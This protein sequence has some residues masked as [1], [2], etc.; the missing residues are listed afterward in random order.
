MSELSW[1]PEV[2]PPSIPYDLTPYTATMIKEAL[3]KKN[4]NS[5]PGDDCIL[6][7]YL[8]KMPG[9]HALLAELFTNIRDLSE[10]P[11]SW[12][13]S[14]VTLMPKDNEDTGDPTHFRMIALTSNV[15]KLYHTLESS[16][17]MS[18]MISNKY[19]DP[20]AQKA[21]VEGVNGCVE[22]VQVVQEVI[23]NAK[24]NH[25]TAYI[26]WIDLIDA[27]GSIIHML[28]YIVLKHYHLPDQIIIYIK[29]IYSKL[30]GRVKTKDWE[31]NTFEF[32]KGVFQGDPYSGT[33]FLI[34][35][36]PLIEYIKKHKE[37]QGYMI[38]D[39][40]QNTEDEDHQKTSIITTPFA[41]DFNLIS[42]N[43]KQHQNLL[44]DVEQ[45]AQSMGLMFK[46]QKCRSLSIS[47]G[48]VV[49]VKFVLT[50][51]SDINS[52][53]HIETV[54]ERPHKFLGSTITKMNSANDFFKYFKE[55]LEEK[56]KNIDNSKIRGEHKLSI[57]E[58][59]TLPSMRF[60][61]SIHDIHNTHLDQLDN[62]VKKYIK[63]WLKYPTRG[64]T[65]IG[66][67][68]PYMLKVKQPSQLYL[69]GH[70]GNIAMMR[71]KGDIIVNKC[72][73]SKINR[74]TKWKKKS[75][76]VVKC[77]N[78]VAELVK[79]N[80]LSIPRSTSISKKHINQAKKEVKIS[81][82]A[83]I[84]EKWD[85]K[86]KKLVMQGNFAKLLLE[87]KENATW[88][89]IA[90]KMPRNVLA[91][92]TRIST[93][94]LPSPDNLKRWGKRKISTCP[95]CRNP[96]GTLAHLVN[97]CPVA[98]KQKR[99]TWRHDSV[100]QHLTKEVKKLATEDTQVYSD[101][102]GHMIN[103]TTIPADILVTSGEGS[104]PDLVLINRRER[105][106]ALL[107]LTCPLEN[108]NRKAHD[109]KELKYTQLQIDLEEK[110]FQVQLVP[111]E[112]GSSGHIT[113]H[114][115]KSLE[116]VL[117]KYS[118]RMKPQVVQNLAKISLL[119]TMSIFHAYQTI[120]WV[121]PPL[122]EP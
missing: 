104:K 3:N 71:I 24:S 107:E 25:K 74:E 60:H 94:S 22:H 36:N 105:R 59:Y 31:T 93:N 62:I 95:L 64:V 20:S 90:H 48:K 109:K 89:S 61:L 47:S 114:T 111:F 100:L 56:V 50:D 4:S 87:E 115:R 70:A 21:Y 86:V 29:N 83:E 75:S 106:I 39:Q 15:G 14:R 116:D 73:D 44:S 85:N 49:N 112:V 38:E 27:F 120:E 53:V 72:L 103:C 117:K 6:Y 102:P 40:E 43:R 55:V 54:H 77:N 2:P 119:C 37:T 80:K 101:L 13:S 96:H 16:R 67:F 32:L 99:F 68:H 42:R 12:A 84:K 10:A 9:T 46:P 58:R 34:V 45:K 51:P 108:N 23:Q 110:G 26:T 65:D 18:F 1:F 41:D 76:T 91:F 78:I 52:K 88:Q 97:I 118:I 98:L 57:Y 66:I 28:I 35:F 8:K 79:N 63:K 5:A 122:L 33:I 69:E 92:A 30:K 82:Q 113:N 19:L 11:D 17:T 121:S 81:I 7:E